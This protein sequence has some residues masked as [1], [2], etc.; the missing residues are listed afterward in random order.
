MG[1]LAVTSA[2]PS[3]LVYRAA[4]DVWRRNLYLTGVVLLLSILAV[5][6]FSKS[7]SR[8]VLSLVRAAER[9]EGGEYEIALE[10]GTRDELGLLT[11]SFVS[12]GKGLAERERVKETFGKFVNKE[13]AE[14]ALKGNLQLGGQRKTATIFF[15]DIALY[16][17]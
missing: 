12:M 4:R 2:T 9:I 16:R 11:E 5:W 8:P 17:D 1:G 7:V 6:F 13:I 3:D 10:S 14:Q 15:S